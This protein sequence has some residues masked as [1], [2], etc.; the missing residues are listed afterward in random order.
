MFFFINDNAFSSESISA[1][2][3]LRSSVLCLENFST[4]KGDNNPSMSIKIVLNLYQKYILNR[5]NTI[6]V[7][8]EIE[9]ENLKIISTNKNIKLIPHG[10]SEVNL[11][12]KKIFNGVK[13]K[14]YFFPGYM[15]RKEF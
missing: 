3:N 2:L 5:V 9:K 10:T 1:N 11:Q 6:H 7:T 14:H 15:K 4:L 13:K 8:S 12:N